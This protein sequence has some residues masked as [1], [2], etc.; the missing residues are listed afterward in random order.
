MMRRALDVLSR[1]SGLFSAFFPTMIGVT[2]LLRRT[3]NA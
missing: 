2:M 3:T 1:T